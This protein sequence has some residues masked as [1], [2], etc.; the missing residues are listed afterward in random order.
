MSASL[1]VPSEVLK[2]RFVPNGATMMFS[3]RCQADSVK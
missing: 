2:Y 3:A 1:S